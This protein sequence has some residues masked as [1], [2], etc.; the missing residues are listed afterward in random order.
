MYSGN[1]EKNIS[2][3]LL[4]NYMYAF[5][6]LKTE[7]MIDIYSNNDT[8]KVDAQDYFFSVNYEICRKKRSG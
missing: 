3:I 8:I 1:Q 7:K 5:H 2:K 6:S 4:N